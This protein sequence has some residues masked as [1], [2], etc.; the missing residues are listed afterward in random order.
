M[1]TKK[2]AAKRKKGSAKKARKSAGKRKTARK[3]K[4]KRAAKKKT[5]TK[6]APNAAFMK[7]MQPSPQLANVVGSSPL[8]RTEVTKKLWAYI[9]RRGLQDAKERR[10]INADENLKPIFNG[11][12]KV[13]MFDMTK[14]V[15]KHL[16]NP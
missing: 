6:R 15:S 14:L 4:V 9:K 7:P 10:M 1:A 2:K 16:K 12:T 8:P 5:R 3:S 11:K 13:S